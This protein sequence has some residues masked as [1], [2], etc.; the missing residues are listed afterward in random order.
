MRSEMQMPD[1]DQL[2]EKQRED[3]RRNGA[4]VLKRR[5]RRMARGLCIYCDQPPRAGKQA[6]LAC[7]ILRSVY[8]RKRKGVLQDA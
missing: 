6:C 5:K 8:Y 1:L 4:N 2:L 3:R 7:A